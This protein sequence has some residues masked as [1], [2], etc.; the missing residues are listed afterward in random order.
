MK[1]LKLV[2]HNGKAEYNAC[3]YYNWR[4]DWLEATICKRHKRG[5]KLSTQQ[6]QEWYEAEKRSYENQ[7]KDQL[8]I[9]KLNKPLAIIIPTHKYHA[10]WHEAVFKQL[11]STGYWTLLAHD[12]P[13]YQLND[14]H[15]NILPMISTTI[16]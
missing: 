15:E 2:N 9:D 5:D 1:R 8:K 6:Y 14:K 13:Y 16:K 11:Y 3:D 10:I 4:L 12:N 7:R